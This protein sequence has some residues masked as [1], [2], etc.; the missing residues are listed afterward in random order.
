MKNYSKIPIICSFV[1]LWVDS[2]FSNKI[3]LLI[4]FF[5]IFSFGILHGAND[6]LLIQKINGEKSYKS[7]LKII[8]YYCIIIAIGIGLFYFIPGIALLLF[9]IV[10]GYHF[11]E[12]HWHFDVVVAKWFQRLFHFIYGTLLLLLLFYIKAK[13]VSFIIFSITKVSIPITYFQNLFYIFS[14]ILLAFFYVSY[15]KEV[16]SINK[17]I[18][19]IFHLII[20]AILFK[21]TE[22]IWGFAIYFVF[23]HS[24]PSIIDQ[25][26]FINGTLS[27][28]NWL[29][30]IKSAALY[31][32]MSLIGI[33][34]LYSILKNTQIFNAVFFSFLAAIT[35][36]HVLVI[37]KMF[38]LKK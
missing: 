36:P 19:E 1:G 18:L 38:D 14:I 11:G 7:F 3:Q 31:W 35:F 22:L 37:F 34:I 17:L 13:E 30:Y 10:S 12:Q 15:K 32:M 2:F 33:F 21:A 24:I 9:I 29:K 5:F 6:L 27:V 4:G 23:W 25:I 16:F 8:T 20:F 28:K 26:V